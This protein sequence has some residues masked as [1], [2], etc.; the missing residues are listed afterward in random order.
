VKPNSENYTFLNSNHIQSDHI[1]EERQSS[2]TAKDI[3]KLR[4]DSRNIEFHYRTKNIRTKQGH[5]PVYE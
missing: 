1:Q 5:S 3:E 2:E 4:Y